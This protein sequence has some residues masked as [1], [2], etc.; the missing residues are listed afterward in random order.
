MRFPVSILSFVLACV[1]GA[2]LV[3]LR[4]FAVEWYMPAFTGEETAVMVGHRVRN[5]YWTD[6]FAGSK[7]QKMAARVLL[8]RLER[9]V[10]SELK[11][12]RQIGISSLFVGT[13]RVKVSRWCRTLAGCRAAFSRNGVISADFRYFSCCTGQVLEARC[14]CDSWV[15]N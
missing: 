8:L 7:C 4:T 9:V 13:S 2:G 1:V 12:F 14:G 6:R 11:K 10:L 3:Y 15:R 5:I